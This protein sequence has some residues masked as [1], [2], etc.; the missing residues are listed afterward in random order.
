MPKN[1]LSIP[2]TQD[3]IAEAKFRASKMVNRQA[4]FSAG[5]T[6]VPIPGLD[7]AVDVTV[8]IKMIDSINREFGLTPAQIMQ[9]KTQERLATFEAIH[10]VGAVLIGKIITSELAISVL[11]SLG[12]K[13]AGKQVARWVPIVGQVSAATLGFAAMKYLGQQHI[14]DCE[15]VARR[16]VQLLDHSNKK[17]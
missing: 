14:A 6:L 16:V 3:A 7:M 9:L 12:V 4:L 2:S 1:E 11:K 17:L 13:V 10:W 8:M 5:M 15:A